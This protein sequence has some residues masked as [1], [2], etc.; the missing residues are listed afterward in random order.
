MMLA[1]SLAVAAVSLVAFVGSVPL[2]NAQTKPAAA[3]A[4]PKGTEPEKA[5]KGAPAE[6]NITVTARPMR[7]SAVV[8]LGKILPDIEL[9][10]L[11]QDFY[12][13]I[14]GLLLSEPF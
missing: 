12:K 5:T 7:P 11:R 13:Q 2:A 3:A 10:K 8:D 1:R 6:I 4:S 14:E 9:S